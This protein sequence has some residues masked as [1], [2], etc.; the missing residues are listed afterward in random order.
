MH[1]YKHSFETASNAILCVDENQ[2]IIA[3]NRQAEKIFGYTEAEIKGRPLHLL[4]PE[5]FK[6]A[7][8]NYVR[9]F[10]RGDIDRKEMGGRNVLY[11]RKKNGDEFP[12]EISISKF[13][14]NGKNYFLAIARDISEKIRLLQ[15]LQQARDTA[16][17]ANK[18]KTNFLVN[19]SHE[20]RTPLNA[21][22]GMT[23]LVLDT[24]LDKE[25]FD[26][27]NTIQAAANGL[28]SLVND[29]LDFSKIEAGKITLEN[30]AFNL[31]QVAEEVV[32]MFGS[33]SEEKDL[34]LILNCDPNI[35]DSLYG[36]VIRLRHILINV[37]G[38]AVKFTHK[39]E[40]T[41]TINFADRK[42]YSVGASDDVKL[43]FTVSDTGIGIPKEDVSKVFDKFS[44]VDSSLSRKYSGTGLGLHICE[45]LLHLMGGKIWLESQENVG[46]SVYFDHNFEI[47]KT[48]FF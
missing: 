48:H 38:N 3:F 7:H 18:V 42:S 26:F 28:F 24:V 35:P 40:I 5:K 31:I 4:L 23:E 10:A 27:V 13:M 34:E 45:K 46:T 20:I 29:I 37:V 15:D 1:F 44:Q 14:F 22:I 41:V 43:L 16:E 12:A 33:I 21:I 17:V 25:Q 19:M 6:K 30:S 47:D 32:D 39:G 2:C 9:D 11:G 36:D 8:E